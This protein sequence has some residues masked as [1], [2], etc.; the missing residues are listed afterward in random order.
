MGNKGE[1]VATRTVCVSGDGFGC[2]LLVQVRDG[3]I[4]KVDPADFPNSGDR[5]ACAR[6]LAIPE[7]VYHQDRLRYPLKRLGER[8]E[9]KW[10][11]V[12]WDEA[13]D[14]IAG[15]LQEV[16]Q[17]YGSTSVAWGAPSWPG[18]SG[19]GYSR[20]ASLTKGTWVS[21]MGY[22][23]AA[24]PC[25]DHA[26]FGRILG[27]VHLF[28]IKDPKFSIVWGFNPA[29]TSY[30]RM[31]RIIEDK[32]KGCKVV[33]IDPL[34]TP[35]AAHADEHIPI[36]P[37]T[38]GALALGM[39]HVVLEQG[40]QD[41]RFI[42]E[43]TVGPLLVRGDNGLFLRESDLIDG[44]SEQQFIVFDKHSRRPQPCDVPGVNPALTGR[45]SISGVDCK[46]AYQLLADLASEYTPERAAE[47]TDVP[48]DVIRRLATSYATQKPAAIHRG[49]GMQ[50][51]FYSDL[52]CR[53]INA[54]AA[55]TGNINPGLP[56]SFVLNMRPFYMPAGPYNNI[57]VM[58]LYDAI[59]KGEPLP[60]KAIW[61]AGHNFVNQLPNMNRIVT[62]VFPQLELI[63]VCDLFMNAT[64]KYADYVLPV[65][66]FCECSDLRTSY[67]QNIYLQLQQKV[68]EP[69][70]ESKSDFQIAAELGRKM[71]FGEFFDKTEEQYI[72]ELLASGH[73]S[74]EG[75]TLEKLREAP[76][77]ASPV[78]RPK[79]FRTPT[80]R[81][82]FYVERLKRFGQELPTYLE[83]VESVRSDKAR[84][85]P[86]CL[87]STHSRYRTH[88]TF[89]N[90]PRLLKLD[91]EPALEISPADAEPRDIS[92]GD[93]VRVFNARG[94]AKLRAKLSQRVKPGV[95][96]ISQGWWPEQ[97]IEGHHNQLTHD[98]INEAQQFILEPNAAL[99]DVLVEVEKV[100]QKGIRRENVGK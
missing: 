44:G 60:I 47:I 59:T 89:A 31:R 37:G 51:S 40:L 82:E 72:E 4:T 99:F 23:D 30:V 83:P 49:W 50:R 77:M 88:S 42:A 27:E 24:G 7:L 90:V 74:V 25:A 12:S 8:G 3:A 81:I 56:S 32:K 9:G 80:G 73:P 97:Y 14:S 65:A 35:T 75:I 91:P 86:L 28:R 38:D 16:G 70:Y 54:L 61:F 29:A 45:Y 85:Y 48:A 63:V 20:L 52:A 58:M 57:P 39:I 84:A 11:R 53:A 5:G 68:I 1:N 71:G 26:T 93:V 10:Q 69:L 79:Q 55:I 98:R 15:K 43:N 6:G 17:R 76:V 21:W 41:E 19:G 18:L 33:V 87:L 62:E 13:L 78:D 100:E 64:A 22:G 34:F 92:D 67:L 96:N 2:G 94:Q 95:V 46:P 36:R 66:S